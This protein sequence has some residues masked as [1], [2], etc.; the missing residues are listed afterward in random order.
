MRCRPRSRMS[1][2]SR[3]LSTA[4]D[5]SRSCMTSDWRFARK[6]ES[7]L[8][9]RPTR[10][11]TGL[12]IGLRSS[13]SSAVASAREAISLAPNSR[14]EFT[15]RSSPDS[16]A[17]SSSLLV[18]F[19]LPEILSGACFFIKIGVDP[20]FPSSVFTVDLMISGLP[21]SASPFS[22]RSFSSF[23]FVDFNSSSVASGNA[24]RSARSSLVI[25]TR[26][27][28]SEASPK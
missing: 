10:R 4:I 21:E 5:G 11:S 28:R 12:E 1:S 26:S 22:P 18:S 23:A 19:T 8:R 3:S 2:S 16:L 14:L 24:A 27:F 7:V 25:L 13:T 17:S 6:P 20:V 15:C 9:P